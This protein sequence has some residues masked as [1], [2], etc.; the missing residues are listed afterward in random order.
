MNI[1]GIVAQAGVI[2]MARRVA[3]REKKSR[4]KRNRASGDSV[5]IVAKWH[6][7]ARIKRGKRSAQQAAMASHRHSGI[8]KTAS[9][10]YGGKM[11]ANGKRGDVAWRAMAHINNRGIISKH[12][13]K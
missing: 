6:Q 9:A 13:S 2:I 11:S 10:E 4:Q 5:G 1:S 7:K 8:A 12:Q 3:K